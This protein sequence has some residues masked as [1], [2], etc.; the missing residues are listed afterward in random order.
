M[1]Q[2]DRIA[3]VTG[4]SQGLGL[5]TVRQLAD[6]GMTV[7]LT[8]RTQARIDKAL[9]ELGKP[10]NVVGHILDVADQASVDTFFDWLMQTHRRIDVLVNNAGRIAGDRWETLETPPEAIAE[11]ID[12]NALGAWRMIQEALPAMNRAGHGRIVN[13]SSGMGALTDMGS[14]SVPY[15]L[16]KTAMNAITRIASNEAR[17]DVH[18]NVVCPGWVR[19]SMGGPGARLSVEE[20]ASGIV[21]AATL[22]A[23]GPNGGF[24]RHG[25]PIEW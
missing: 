17:G 15:R 20:G 25:K 24:F 2:S 22:P 16:S 12:N 1:S 5:E 19:T 8:A 7:V 21:W 4:A 3:V 11:L 9:G 13:V 10:P 14:G 6:R 23:D 18:V